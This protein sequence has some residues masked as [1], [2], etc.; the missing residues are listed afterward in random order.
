MSAEQTPSSPSPFEGEYTGDPSNRKVFSTCFCSVAALAVTAGR[1]IA[2]QRSR[3]TPS[4]PP[5]KSSSEAAVS[6][7]PL[8]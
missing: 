3:L 5:S 4:V 2:A 8:T 1:P 6:S 7:C